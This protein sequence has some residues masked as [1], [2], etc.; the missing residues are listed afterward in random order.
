MTPYGGGTWASRG[1]GIGGEAALQAARAL[2]DSILEVAASMLQADQAQLDIRD[3][4][5]VDSTSGEARMPLEELGR[6]VYFRGD[7]LPKG[8][9]RSLSRHGTSSRPN[10][11]LPSPTASRPPTSRSIRRPAS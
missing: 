4:A 10:T 2:R 11:P 6:I 9:P 3:G 8:L 7:T 1:A 5:V